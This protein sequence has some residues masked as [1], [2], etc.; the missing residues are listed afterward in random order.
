MKIKDDNQT[1]IEQAVDMAKY[2]ESIEWDILS[3]TAQLNN[4]KNYEHNNYEEFY[5]GI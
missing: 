3:V 4:K 1:F 5:E 2:A